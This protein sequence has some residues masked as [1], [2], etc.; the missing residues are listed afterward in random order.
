M[1]RG[2][3]FSA[4][5]RFKWTQTPAEI[6]YM[7]FKEGYHIAN[8][9][10]NSRIFCNKIT[11]LETLENLNLAMQSASE[12]MSQFFKSVNEFTPATYRL[13]IVS[14]LVKFL[15]CDNEGLWLVKNSNSN[16][17]KGIEMVADIQIYKDSLL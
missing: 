1:G 17:G 14:D 15:N 12:P 11:T 2:F 13:D 8:H 10:S 5:Y 4:D 3:A 16:Q 6:N 9:F 7:Q